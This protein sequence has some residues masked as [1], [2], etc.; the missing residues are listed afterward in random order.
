M[1]IEGGGGGGGEILNV[2]VVVIVVVVEFAVVELADVGLV[3]ISLPSNTTK[4][5][6]GGTNVSDSLDTAAV[7]SALV[8]TRR[9]FANLG[10]TSRRA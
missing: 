3:G 2:V 8:Y 7:L 10:C 1:R 4:K 5:W 6:T 9:R